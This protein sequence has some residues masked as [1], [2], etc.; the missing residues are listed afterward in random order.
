MQVLLRPSASIA[1]LISL[2]KHVSV[3]VPVRVEDIG[4]S[5]FPSAS[6]G[7]KVRMYRLLPGEKRAYFLESV[8]AGILGP[9]RERG[10]SVSI[11]RAVAP[12]S[13]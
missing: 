7:I 5:R 6:A 12:F 2:S 13:A 9:L 3:H 10:C 1:E 4:F 8:N 11:S